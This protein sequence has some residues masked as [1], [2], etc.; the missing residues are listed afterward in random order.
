MLLVPA[1]KPGREPGAGR[2]RPD[3]SLCLYCSL[4]SSLTP[5]QGV[6][7]GAGLAQS[8]SSQSSPG[9]SW[10]ESEHEREKNSKV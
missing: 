9:L 4:A 7:W 6:T 1:L 3:C 8:Y 5:S 10:E 2:W